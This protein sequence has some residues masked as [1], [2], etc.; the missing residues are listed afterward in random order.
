MVD[1]PEEGS[2]RRGIAAVASDGM[3][4]QRCQDLCRHTAGRTGGSFPV[5]DLK[6]LT[7]SYE[8]VTPT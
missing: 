6:A 8:R 1:D 7:G 3:A 4:G 2:V 5:Q